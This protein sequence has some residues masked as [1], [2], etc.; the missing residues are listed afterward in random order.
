MNSSFKKV[1]SS[2]VQYYSALKSSCVLLFL[3]LMLCSNT[4]QAQTFTT[5]FFDIA[6]TKKAYT[7]WSDKGS[8][9]K[10]IDIYIKRPKPPKGYFI[11]GDMV[12]RRGDDASSDEFWSIAVKPKPGFEHLLKSPTMYVFVWDDRESGADKNCAIWK[13]LCPSGYVPL[14]MV[15]T[16]GS[17]WNPNGGG[18]KDCKCI[19]K[20]IRHK[21]K[22]I[23]IVK[24]INYISKDE[25]KVKG[26]WYDKGSGGKYDVALFKIGANQ[27]YSPPKNTLLLA[28][29]TF[30]IA[31][32][33]TK[34][35]TY[36]PYALLAFWN[37]DKVMPKTEKPKIPTLLS[38]QDPSEEVSG[39]MKTKNVY[40]LPFFMV[41]D[42]YYSTIYKQAEESPFY[43][44]I[45][46][47]YYKKGISTLGNGSGTKISWSVEKSEQKSKHQESSVGIELSTSVTLGAEVNAAPLG[48]GGSASLSRSFGISLNASHAWGGSTTTGVS[49]SG[50]I[51]ENVKNGQRAVIY[52]VVSDY[53]IIRNKGNGGSVRGY[54]SSVPDYSMEF[55]TLFYPP[56]EASNEITNY[57]KY[58]NT[59]K[60]GEILKAG[61]KLVSANG[62]YMVVLQEDGHLCVFEHVNGKKGIYLWC[63][64]VHGFK[65]GKLRMGVDG[66][67][68]VLDQN[69]KYK[70]GS[71]QNK[72]Y[73]I[74]RNANYKLVLT[75][76]GKL[77]VVSPAG[78]L[79]W[80]N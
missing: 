50:A 40:Y 17:K 23:D 59:L 27:N 65:N 69:N 10:D 56:N 28:P 32:N 60:S 9:A 25:N 12:G 2:R 68:C 67:L 42:D 63:S 53:E 41:K 46:R 6:Y 71:Y 20:S 48:I 30:F 79:M 49:R 51:Q 70:W 16:E 37:S 19:K 3:S 77:N 31:R 1:Y 66:N 39:A 5:E 55:V 78:T 76:K 57:G 18:R 7:I 44:V 80:S 33:Y 43:K 75:N 11:F 52:E 74:G 8:G 62:K 36:T 14:G 73:H 24:P 72:Q 58:R 34:F 45:K 61:E 22:N 64:G 29:N 54:K 13:L 15:A 21:G 47:S 4:T 35:P 26:F 38:T